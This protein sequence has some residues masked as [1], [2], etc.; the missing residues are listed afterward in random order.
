M[1]AGRRDQDTLAGPFHSAH[2]GFFFSGNNLLQTTNSHTDSRQHTE[3]PTHSSNGRD[4]DV[5]HG[6]QL[7]LLISGPG[8]SSPWALP[9]EPATK[10]LTTVFP[11]WLGGVPR[12]RNR[13]DAKR[14]PILVKKRG[15]V[16]V[17]AIGD[18][19][20]AENL[21]SVYLFGHVS[22]RGAAMRKQRLNIRAARAL[23]ARVGSEVAGT[24]GNGCFAHSGCPSHIHGRL[25]GRRRR[26]LSG[27]AMSKLHSGE[28]PRS[29]PCRCCMCPAVAFQRV[30]GRASVGLPLPMCGVP[31]RLG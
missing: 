3:T 10:A 29:P 18:V 31:R 13:G 7:G 2:S 20:A 19:R 28:R 12:R 17:T 9:A 24:A 23:S 11:P 6:P 25:R 30:V 8:S 14:R 1:D 22:V 15:R 26:V 16:A 5:P 4:D 27:T 21:S